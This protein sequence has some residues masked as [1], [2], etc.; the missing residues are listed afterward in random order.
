MLGLVIAFALGGF[1]IGSYVTYRLAPP[2][3]RTHGTVA[4]GLIVCVLVGAAVGLTCMYIYLAIY[5]LI[6]EPSLG[7]V[8]GEGKSHSDSASPDANIFVSAVFE[9]ASQSGVLL[10]LAVGLYVLSP[11][12]RASEVS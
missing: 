2:L 7:L 6:H 1:A 5:G 12:A 8:I 3:A 10:A 4:V 11:S 9:I